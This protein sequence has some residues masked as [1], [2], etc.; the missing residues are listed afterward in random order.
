MIG[1]LALQ[2]DFREHLESLQRLKIEAREIRS[3]DDLKQV[4]ALIMPGGESTVMA[5]LLVSSG[6]DEAIKS[7][8][9]SGMPV[10]GTCAG[11]ILLA[12]NIISDI[13]LETGIKAMDMEIERNS[14]GRQADS[15]ILPM[16]FSGKPFQAFFVR[17]PRITK[18]GRGIKVLMEYKKDPILVRSKNILVSTFHP[19]LSLKNPVLEYFINQFLKRK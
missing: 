5:K 17:A 1:V 7:R 2:G 8:I 13:P 10:W 14:Y 19:E 9:K 3:K 11:A 4:D 12:K 18:I 15:F 16:E 6:L